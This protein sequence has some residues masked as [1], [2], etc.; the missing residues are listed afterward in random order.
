MALSVH[1]E[2]V[3]NYYLF[4]QMA[5][6]VLQLT[7]LSDTLKHWRKKQAS[8]DVPQVDTLLQLFGSFKVIMNKIRL[9]LFDKLMP[10]YEF[11]DLRIRLPTG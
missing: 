3:E 4:A 11:S 5:H 9:E 8:D 2:A 10:I 1:T 6:I 7:A